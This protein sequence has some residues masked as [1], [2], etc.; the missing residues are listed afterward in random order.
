MPRRCP[1]LTN[2]APPCRTLPPS[3]ALPTSYHDQPSPDC[4]ALPGQ[5]RPDLT[6][7]AVPNQTRTRLDVPWEVEPK[8]GLEPTTCHLRNGCSAD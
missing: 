5:T 6:T 7:T 8:V 3:P 1:D 4:H 2:L